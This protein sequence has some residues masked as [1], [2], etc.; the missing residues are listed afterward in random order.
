LKTI[1]IERQE[2]LLRIAV[3]ENDKLVECYIEEENNE[4]VP[5]EL[6]KGIVKNIVP[7]IK[8]A[9]IDIGCEKNCYMY[10]DSKFNNTKIKKQ[11]EV[12]VEV[13]KESIGTKGPKVT[14]AVSMPGRY[15]V[16]ETLN[17]DIR[18]SKNIKNEEFKAYISEN[19]KKPEDIG[20]MIRTN[21]EKVGLVE[22]QNEVN[23]L[24]EKLRKVQREGRYSV[25][26]GLL[27]SDAGVMDRVL[28]DR[29]DSKTSSIIVDN[30]ADFQYVKKIV[31]NISDIK[32]DVN[33]HND[34][35]S[36]LNSYG[37]EKEILSL[38]HNKIMLGSGASI[39]IDKTEAMYVI[40]VN[41]GKNLSSNSMERTV[42]NTNLEAAEEITRQIKLRNLSGII[43]VDFIDMDN[44]EHKDKVLGILREGFKDDKNATHIYPFTELNL[45]QISRR[46]RGKNI[47]EF[48]EEK[49]ETCEGR[50]KKIKISYLTSIIR[51]EVVK[52][53]R[54]QGIKDIY[55]EMSSIYEKEIL[56]DKIGFIKA[57]EAMDKRVY[58]NFRNK[59]EL[60]KIEPLIF[61]NQIQ[62]LQIY[63]IYG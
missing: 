24:Y 25:N 50:G 28:R 56:E 57:I 42:L 3:R 19:I 14:N 33:L 52:I 63:K 15:T 55:I 10:L 5:G 1:F 54:E 29:V 21:G 35:R 13:L 23:S 17:K 8:C 20:I 51:N 22:L 9:F 31:Q 49:C 11:D 48:I 7:A 27:Y 16:I 12:I 18:F 26:P 53:S 37:I 36:L 47:S 30:E 40:D 59:M 43:V 41:T 58:I 45:V 61:S 39:V 2:N 6:Y 46:R 34:N 38:R 4:P 62:N 32:V 44:K 60:F